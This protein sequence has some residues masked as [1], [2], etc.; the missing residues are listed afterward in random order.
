MVRNPKGERMLRR[1]AAPVAVWAVSRLL[2]R[3]AVR[4]A[5]RRVDARALER[6]ER[7]RRRLR[8]AGR[9]ARSNPAW[10]AAG[11]GAIGIGIGLITHA[12]RRK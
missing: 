2:E 11:I 7:T 3:P 9:N 1:I 6:R 10:M 5:L 4:G 8:R 12:A